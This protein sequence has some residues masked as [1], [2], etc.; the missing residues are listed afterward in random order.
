MDV[1]IMVYFI[2]DW[3]SFEKLW[4]VVDYIIFKKIDSKIV[5]VLV[6]NKSD[7][8]YMSCVINLEVI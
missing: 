8:V 1:I 5:L 4:E 3:K 2:M 6:V 7:F